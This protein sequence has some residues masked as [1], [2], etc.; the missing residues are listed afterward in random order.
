MA[1]LFI[2][3]MLVFSLFVGVLASTYTFYEDGLL[4]SSHW[5]EKGAPTVIYLGGVLDLGIRIDGSNGYGYLI[6]I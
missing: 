2:C 6:L 5:G 4:T 3:V 1:M